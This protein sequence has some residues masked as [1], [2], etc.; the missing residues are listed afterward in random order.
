MVNE[1]DCELDLERFLANLSVSGA[2]DGV[3]VDIISD[4]FCIKLDP[5]STPQGTNGKM[6][7]VTRNSGLEYRKVVEKDAVKLVSGN[8]EVVFSHKKANIGRVNIVV[9]QDIDLRNTN[10]IIW[11]LA[12][13]FRPDHDV[14]FAEDGKILLDTTRIGEK[15]EVPFLP[16]E[17]LTRVAH[18]LEKLLPSKNLYLVSRHI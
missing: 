16:Q 15:L 8:S 6:I 2:K 18:K 4:V 14:E 12:T 7:L 11:A 5:S 3:N 1:G 9:D 13:R 17:I 10:Q